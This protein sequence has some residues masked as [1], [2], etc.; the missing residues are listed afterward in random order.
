MTNFYELK[1]GKEKLEALLLLF[2]EMQKIIPVLEQTRLSDLEKLR[3]DAIIKLNELKDIS[4]S[5]FN[6]ANSLFTRTQEILETIANDKE[7]IKSISSLANE[8]REIY[9]W[10]LAFKDSLQR[11]KEYI[12]NTKEYITSLNISIKQSEE[13]ALQSERNAKNSENIAVMNAQKISHDAQSIKAD[14]KNILALS[15]VDYK[16]FDV[17]DDGGLYV[18]Y[19]D[20]FTQDVI[21]NDDGGLYINYDLG[22]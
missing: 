1:L 16:S 4:F 22:V 3:D 20:D 12:A 2:E 19:N 18:S 10:I 21:I 14:A 17:R 6:E 5:K 9:A 7:Y 8:L 13:N 11:D 15:S